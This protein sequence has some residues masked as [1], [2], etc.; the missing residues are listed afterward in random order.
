MSEIESDFT[1]KLGPLPVWVYGIL[2]AGGYYLYQKHKTSTASAAT[3]ASIDPATGVPYATELAT[4]NTLQANQAAGI[5]PNTGVPYASEGID[6]NTGIPFTE[7]GAVGGSF[8]TATDAY[9]QSDPTMA[10]YPVGAVPA[11]APAPVTNAQWARLAGDYLTGQGQDPSLVATALSD[12]TS[13]VP[14]SASEQAIVN[15][16]LQTFGEPPQGVIP[17]ATVAAPTPITNP[18]A[19]A[20]SGG[21]ITAQAL[22][23]T[24]GLADAYAKAWGVP[25]TSIQYQTKTGQKGWAHAGLPIG[26]GTHIWTTHVRAAA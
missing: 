14:I 11:G 18:R 5:D 15:E 23:T 19:P 16:A 9:L 24:W 22:V 4:A 17:V 6:P 10:A 12:Y 1:E 20:K 21:G 2:L 8:N 3:R 26:P 25:V 7:E 13:G